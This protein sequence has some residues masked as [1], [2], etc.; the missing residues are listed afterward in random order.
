MKLQEI[1]NS[2]RSADAN[3]FTCAGCGV[4]LTEHNT[5][6]L[7]SRHLATPD[8]SHSDLRFS[9][10]LDRAEQI[11][12]LFNPNSRIATLYGQVSFN[13]VFA[14][15]QLMNVGDFVITDHQVTARHLFWIAQRIAFLYKLEYAD[16]VT[17]LHKVEELE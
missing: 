8:C 11:L 10:R 12:T 3:D 14:A 1:C 2:A 17:A 5:D 15:V 4:P 16:G 6:R 7:F 9:D 13:N